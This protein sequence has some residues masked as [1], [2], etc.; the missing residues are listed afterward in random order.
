MND[1]FKIKFIILFIIKYIFYMIFI[2]NNDFMKWCD[3]LWKVSKNDG[4]GV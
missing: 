4:Q 1:F 2:Y 3:D